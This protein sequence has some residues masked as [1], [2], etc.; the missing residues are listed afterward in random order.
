MVQKAPMNINK[1]RDVTR[2]GGSPGPPSGAG[3][4][5]R[6]R[7][8]AP[9]GRVC[10]GARPGSARINY[11][12]PLPSASHGPTTYGKTRWG[13]VRSHLGGGESRGSRRTRPGWQKLALGTWNI[14]SLW[15]KEPE[16][17]R[18]VARYQLD[19][20][21]LTSMH[22]LSSGTVLLDRGWTLFFFGVAEGVRRRASVGILTNPWLS[23]VVL[24]FTPVDEGLWGGK[25]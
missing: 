17:V 16:L 3:P 24:E 9:G 12:A 4:G 20:V 15:G 18:E 23:A 14:T 6:A 5:R 21:G 10:H 1:R 25:L 8:R 2:P 11:V 22:S 13:R 19:L 7:Q